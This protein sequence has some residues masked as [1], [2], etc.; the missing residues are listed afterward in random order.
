MILINI[1][2]MVL[3]ILVPVLFAYV[4]GKG[5]PS[6]S[7]AK[8]KPSTKGKMILTISTWAILVWGLTISG[9]FSYKMGDMIPRFTIALLI[10]VGVGVVLLFSENFRKVIDT[11]PLS[12]LVGM[13]T[14]RI[15]GFVF[16]LVAV[17]G[18]GPAEFASAGYADMITGSLALIA[19]I[20]L[21]LNIKSGFAVAWVFNAIGLFDLA[22]VSRL[23]LFNYPIWSDAQPSSAAMADF[24]LMLIVGLAAPV[25]LL[26]HIYSI[27]RLL[28]KKL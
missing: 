15:L 12:A 28:L 27:R 26:V 6:E 17:K 21:W 8:G 20:L 25:A 16:L 3:G 4:L 22:N 13:E 24:P 10:P 23:L 7:S 2:S 1:T 14:F 9:A 5:Y 18:L 19:G 11:I